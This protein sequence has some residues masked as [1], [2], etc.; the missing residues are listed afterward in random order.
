MG[1]C[2]PAASGGE[3]LDIAGARLGMEPNGCEDRSSLALTF[4]THPSLV[5][6]LE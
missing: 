6:L 3:R 2:G 5:G 1:D 4:L